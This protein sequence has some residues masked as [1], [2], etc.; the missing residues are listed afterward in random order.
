VALDKFNDGIYC[1]LIAYQ[2]W[3]ALFALDLREAS[4]KSPSDFTR[5]FGECLK[6]VNYNPQSGMEHDKT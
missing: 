5:K 3:M 1:K 6:R 4:K 2:F